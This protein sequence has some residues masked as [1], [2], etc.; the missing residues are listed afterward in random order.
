MMFLISIGAYLFLLVWACLFLKGGGIRESPKPPQL[1]DIEISPLCL[2]QSEAPS[3]VAFE[4]GFLGEWGDEVALFMAPLAQRDY[5]SN[6]SEQ[7]KLVRVPFHSAVE[8]ASGSEDRLRK[9]G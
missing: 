7:L 9:T 1:A 3:T 8:L 5:C 4:P 2:M 6:W